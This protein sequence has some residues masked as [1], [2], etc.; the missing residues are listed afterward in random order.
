[1]ALGPCT[2]RTNALGLRMAHRV[3]QQP[4]PG[5]TALFRTKNILRATSGYTH[6]SEALPVAAHVE[7]PI[8][9]LL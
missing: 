4:I 7:A 8:V 3:A 1:M 6:P 2:G 5:Q 9:L